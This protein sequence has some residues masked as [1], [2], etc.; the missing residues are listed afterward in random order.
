VSGS[1]V[2]S[3]TKGYVTKIACPEVTDSLVTSVV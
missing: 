1:K 3:I 2:H